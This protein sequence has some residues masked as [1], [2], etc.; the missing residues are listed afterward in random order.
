MMQKYYV[1]KG[2]HAK[3]NISSFL[4]RFVTFLSLSEDRPMTKRDTNFWTSA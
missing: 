4:V 2:V 1:K 3:W